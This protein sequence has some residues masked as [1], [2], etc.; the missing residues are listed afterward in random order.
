MTVKPIEEQGFDLNKEEFR[1]SL[2]LRY[3]M[4]IEDL[5]STCACGNSFDANHAMHCKN[6]GYVIYRHNCI[7]D[8]EAALLRKVC[9]DVS[10]EPELQPVNRDHAKSDVKARGLWRFGQAAY[11]DVT[12]TNPNAPSQIDEDVLSILKKHENRKK[13]QYNERILNNERGSFTPLVFSIN[14]V[15]SPECE[16]YHKHLA[17][18]IATKYHQR[19]EQ[20]IGWI[21]CKLS[22]MII[23][24]SLLCLRGS[25]HANT[26]C[27]DEF[28]LACM[29]AELHAH[30]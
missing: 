6:G 1:D 16:K 20:V 28:D 5:P 9:T 21:R 17:N 26:Q 30:K 24:S 23:K 3:G 19:Y 10:I 8:F 2:R 11:L 27:A 18:K 29:D 14:G 7:R 4:H 25:R 15:M 13:K 22:F 12:L